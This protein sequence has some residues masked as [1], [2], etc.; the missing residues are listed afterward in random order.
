M[1]PSGR[2]G[3]GHVASLGW[4]KS[5][6]QRRVRNR[7]WLGAARRWRRPQRWQAVAAVSSSS[8]RPVPVDRA[9]PARSARCVPHLFSRVLTFE[10]A[11]CPLNALGNDSKWSRFRVR[12][13]R[14]AARIPRMNRSLFSVRRP[15]RRD[16]TSIRLSDGDADHKPH[17]RTPPRPPQPQGTRPPAPPSPHGRGGIVSCGMQSLTRGSAA[18]HRAFVHA[19]PTPERHHT[20]TSWR[21]RSG[22]RSTRQRRRGGAWPPPHSPCA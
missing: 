21:R 3:G 7:R 5:R 2:G 12:P 17:P 8:V 13:D 22:R 10:G 11:A 16:R 4:P 6:W 15:H 9:R 14:A 19:R 1:H 18:P 20:L